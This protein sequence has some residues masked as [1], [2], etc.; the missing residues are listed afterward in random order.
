MFSG[1][2]IHKIHK[3]ISKAERKVLLKPI[4]KHFDDIFESNMIWLI[5]HHLLSVVN[6]FACDHPIEFLIILKSLHAL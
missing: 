6:E 4:L 1:F 3:K 5:S 2:A